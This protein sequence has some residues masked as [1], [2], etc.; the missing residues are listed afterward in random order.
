MRESGEDTRSKRQQILDAA[1][2]VFS[3][4]GYHRATIDEIIALAD[5]GKGTV[6]N[7]FINK[8]QLF[9][10]L[11]KER[12]APFE[13]A[14]AEV[15]GGVEPPLVKVERLI[16]LFLRFYVA[17]A[18]LWRVMM[19]EVRGFGSEGQSTLKEEQREKYRAWFRHT[20]GMLEKVLQEGI[21]QG[22]IRECDVTKAAYGLFSVIVM[23]VF[24]KFV[25]DDIDAT[26]KTI[27]DIFLYGV[28][29]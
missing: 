12:S 29:R 4:K 20:I 22:V 17:N 13:A 7:Y 26:A 24:Q 16:K 19:H 2:E 1:Y 21:D 28:A 6:Y 5:T 15:V 8:E 10:T 14:L 23:M 25:G 3:Q 27:A 11:I 18:D 9:Y